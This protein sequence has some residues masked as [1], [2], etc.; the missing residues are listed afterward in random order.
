MDRTWVTWS[1]AWCVGEDGREL[2]GGRESVVGVRD[3]EGAMLK[4][5][6][7]AEAP[8]RLLWAELSS[9]RIYASWCR[10][11]QFIG[12]DLYVR[13]PEGQLQSTEMRSR[14]ICEKRRARWWHI[15]AVIPALKRWRRD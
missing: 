2:P 14:W 8:G 12:L 15:T 9:W 6:K 11:E 3:L 7:I 1:S 5:W 13:G 4:K 10:K